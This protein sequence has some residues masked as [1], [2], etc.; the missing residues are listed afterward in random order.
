MTIDEAL[1]WI[2]DIFE[3]PP[4]R[5][6]LDTP[7]SSIPA[8]DS[9]GM[10]TLMARLDEDLNILLNEGDLQTLQTVGDLID[11]IKSRGKIE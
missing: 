6:A 8:W 3:E 9:L 1:K 10:L 2:A 7:R 4:G 11:V 5:V